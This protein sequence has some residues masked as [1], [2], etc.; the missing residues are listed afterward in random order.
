[1]FNCHQPFIGDYVQAFT[2]CIAAQTPTFLLQVLFKQDKNSMFAH[3][4]IEYLS[5]WI[6]FKI[7][8]WRIIALK[9]NAEDLMLLNCGVGGDSQS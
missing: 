4:F 6:F 5:G 7:F 3:S 1:M 2:E 9:L 8:N